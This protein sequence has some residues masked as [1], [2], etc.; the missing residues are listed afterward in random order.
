M[1]ELPGESGLVGAAP[2]E[3]SGERH[4]GLPDD[5][6]DRPFCERAELRDEGGELHSEGPYDRETGTRRTGNLTQENEVVREEAVHQ[7]NLRS[8]RLDAGQEEG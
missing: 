4:P 1:L 7:Q 8:A 5:R 2:F 6:A 3:I